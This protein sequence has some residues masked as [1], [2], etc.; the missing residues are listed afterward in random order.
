VTGTGRLDLWDEREQRR[1]LTIVKARRGSLFGRRITLT[2]N[3]GTTLRAIMQS[4]RL[5]RR[6]RERRRTA[7][8][9]T[10]AVQP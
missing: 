9:I 5:L 3:D 1:A 7:R 8:A 4:P 10:A 6:G 2:A